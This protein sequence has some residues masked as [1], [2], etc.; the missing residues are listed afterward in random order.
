MFICTQSTH[1]FKVDSRNR[2]ST[3]KRLE[4]FGIFIQLTG[5]FH[6]HQTSNFGE[7]GSRLEV[8]PRGNYQSS[9]F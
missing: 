2:N 4:F 3:L 9:S 1:I 6:R 8:R 7:S 5:I